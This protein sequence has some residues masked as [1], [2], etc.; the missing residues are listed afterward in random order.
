M[1]PPTMKDVA[2]SAGVDVSTVSLALG[3]D[4][5]IKPETRDKIVRVAHEL[6]YRKNHLA[7]GLRSGK[8]LTVGAVVGHATAFWG[9]V[10]AGAQGV[11]AERDYHLLLDYAPFGTQRSEAQQINALL[12]KGVDGFLIAPPD[13]DASR[14]ADEERRAVYAELAG[15]RTPF[16]F[17]DRYVKGV[18]ADR[19]SADNYG[20]AQTAARHLMGLGHKRIAYVFAPHRM[21]T[22]HDDRLAGYMDALHTASNKPN[23]WPAQRARSE[24]SEEGWETTKQKWQNNESDG[25]TA[26]LSATDSTAMGVL[27]ALREAGQNVPRD[28]AVV[29]FGGTFTAE[30]LFPALTTMTLPMRSVG[31]DAAALLLERM[32]GSDGLVQD[33]VL[34]CAL[35]VRESCGGGRK[36]Q[37]A[38][39]TLTP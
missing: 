31:A 1:T 29:S 7:R 14:D 27:R 12:S 34:P 38:Q 35:V 6:G 5:R 37:A 16:V 28:V 11:F 25:I 9:E 2:R 23:L 22:A 30:Y 15:R 20:A 17:V 13:G 39:G 18:P 8:S 4:P 24:R 32:G 33:L 26:I 36:P 10:L 19:V 3:G 21:N